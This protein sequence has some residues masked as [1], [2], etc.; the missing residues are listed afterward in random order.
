MDLVQSVSDKWNVVIAGVRHEEQI[1]ASPS[2]QR[3]NASSRDVG[4][5]ELLSF[6]FKNSHRDN[7]SQRSY[8]AWSS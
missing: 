6:S 1:F 4:D 5:I 2:M 7:I 3:L 8:I